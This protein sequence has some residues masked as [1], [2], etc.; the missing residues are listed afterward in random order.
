VG[1]CRLWWRFDSIRRERRLTDDDALK[2]WMNANVD[3]GGRRLER[4]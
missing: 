4:E 3:R 2:N 1:G